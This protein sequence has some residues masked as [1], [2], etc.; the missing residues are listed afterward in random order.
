MSSENDKS[1]EVGQRALAALYEIA[2]LASGDLET[3]ALLQ[4][5]LG[6]ATRLFGASAGYIAL[7]DPDTG[8]LEIEAQKNLPDDA[9][10]FALRP[11]QGIT[12]G[13][14]YHAKPCLVADVAAEPRYI[15]IRPGVGCV[16]A[17]PLEDGAGRVLGI[18]NLDHERTGAFGGD[19]LA[20][21]ARLA[22]E[23]ASVITRL[24]QFGQLSNKARQFESLIDIGRTFVAKIEQHELLDALVRDTRLVAQCHACALYLY[25]PGRGTVTLPAWSSARGDEP[26][27]K[28]EIPLDSSLVAS[29]IHTRR[30]LDF[31]D[32]RGPDYFELADIPR[33]GEVRSVLAS[34]MI[35]EE[36][37]LGVLAVFTDHAHRFSNDEKR[38][39]DALAGL[40]VVALQNA[41]LYT[42]V[43]QGEALLRKNEQLTT[44]GLL[45]AEI[46]HEI[47]NPLTVIKLLHGN[48][49]LDFPAPD[50]RGTDVRVI[51][52]KLDQLEAI[53]SRVLNFAKA[54]GSVHSRR[55]LADI[56]EDTAV[57]IRLKFAQHKIKL[58][59]EPI[60]ARW[61]VDVNKGQIQQVLLNLLLNSMQAMPDGGVI[62]LGARA[63]GGAV[64]IDIS[65]TGPGVAEE[66]RG[67]LFGSFLSGK[68]GGT[69]LGLA[70][71]KRIM[72]AHH[73]DIALL[74]T[75]ASGTTFRLTLPLADGE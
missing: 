39:L 18:I 58:Y 69:G 46:A 30:Q 9:R 71:A 54:P 37:I 66:V 74:A 53:V 17:A 55:S 34:P 4:K 60:P 43:F 27:T 33:D 45:A 12:G 5:I 22:R 28:A 68:P 67:R 73:G 1:P 25:D 36:E 42:R 44:L 6:C 65:D 14:F 52:E 63:E 29:V 20:V 13:V 32:V 48:L 26:W 16:M 75:G 47:R 72:N 11:G 35:L 19:D 56:V 59:Y 8:K 31:A 64:R 10:E 7:L 38:L 21:F 49:G 62:S 15:S 57:L 41:R 23:A 50:P 40:G 51:G 70:I 3:D 2:S 61:T 24:W